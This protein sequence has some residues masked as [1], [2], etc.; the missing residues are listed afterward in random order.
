[1]G[2]ETKKVVAGA[3]LG[4]GLVLAGGFALYEGTHDQNE[5]SKVAG[6]LE[7]SQAQK[8]VCQGVAINPGAP[9]LKNSV[10]RAMDNDTIEQVVGGA[11]GIL[12]ALTVAG[13]VYYNVRPEAITSPQEIL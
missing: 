9:F 7:P 1:M 5:L 6:C 11:V 2:F 12:G 3:V 8:P 13:T 10:E 4:G